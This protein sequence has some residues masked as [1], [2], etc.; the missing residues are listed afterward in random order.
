VET[1]EHTSDV[2]GLPV[3]WRS[4]GDR[5]ALYL[6]GVPT[7]S[8]IWGP[9]L[10][11]VGGVAPDL[12]GFG[13]SGKP[14]DFDYSIGG[15]ADFLEAFTAEAGLDRMTLVVQDWGGV[16]LAFAQRHPE[17]V[18]RLV[19]FS[20]VPLLPGYRWHRIARAWRTPMLGELTMGL[21]GRW[22]A[23]QV[24][25]EAFSAPGP[26][27]P[28]FVD[29]VW[30]AFDHGTQRAILRLYRS[31]P[32]TVLEEAG[33]RLGVL[34]CPALILPGTKDPYIPER[35]GHDLAA[36]LGGDATVE[37]LEAGHWPWLEQPELVERVA[38]F[39]EGA[40]S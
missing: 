33:T 3:H 22:A 36:A 1:N 9:F 21:T 7:A 14:G 5:P 4:A 13:S 8:W 26:P 23:K 37:P 30:A 19:A 38:R 15:Y 20:S 18:E 16:G 10:E 27:P 2:A 35:F 24:L 32:P 6:H 28:D 17:R 39:I 31:A 40:E 25:R 34:R 11:R 12:P 29:R